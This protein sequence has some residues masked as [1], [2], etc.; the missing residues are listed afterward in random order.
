MR[1]L[2]RGA[3]EV[4]SQDASIAR[5]AAKEEMKDLPEEYML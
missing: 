3:R 5:D 2:L 4:Y 1:I